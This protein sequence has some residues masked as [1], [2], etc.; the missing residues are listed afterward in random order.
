MLEIGA[1]Q[2]GIV[3]HGD[4]VA[5]VA[6][7]D[8]AVAGEQLGDLRPLTVALTEHVGCASPRNAGCRRRVGV[9]ADERGLCIYGDRESKVV[10]VLP[11]VSG[12]LCLLAPHA[13]HGGEDIGGARA[14]REPFPSAARSRDRRRIK[15]RQRVCRFFVSCACRFLGG[16]SLL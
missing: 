8:D 7:S 13:V 10:E 4:G 3:E 9:R 5:E 15:N 1:H 11:V 6:A 2:Q 12:E 14:G 16:E